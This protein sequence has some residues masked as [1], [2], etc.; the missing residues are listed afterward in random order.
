MV[1]EL[2]MYQFIKYF[3]IIMSAR[4]DKTPNKFVYRLLYN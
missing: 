3:K 4:G 2:T 1:F